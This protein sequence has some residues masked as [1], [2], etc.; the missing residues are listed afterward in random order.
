[1]RSLP[2]SHQTLLPSCTMRDRRTSIYPLLMLCCCLLPSGQPAISVLWA[3]ARSARGRCRA[4]ASTTVMRLLEGVGAFCAS[5]R[6]SLEEPAFEVKRKVL[7]LVV[8]RIVVEESRVV[9]QHVVPTGPVR[10]Q[11]EQV[12]QKYPYRRSMKNLKE[13]TRLDTSVQPRYWP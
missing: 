4:T 13:A 9:I 11:T 5:V 12:G 7:Q 8:D 2:A 1:M 6:A 10:L 3:A